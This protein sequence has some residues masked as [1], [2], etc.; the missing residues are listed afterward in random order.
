MKTHNFDVTQGDWDIRDARGKSARVYAPGAGKRDRREKTWYEKASFLKKAAIAGALGTAGLG[1][2]AISR[3]KIRQ[4]VISDAKDL[5][6]GVSKGPA[7]WFVKRQVLAEAVIARAE[8]FAQNEEE[9]KTR[10]TLRKVGI[11]AA[12]LG[13]AALPAALPMLSIS[14]R[15]TFPKL[16]NPKT[17]G[18]AFVSDYIK[19][20]NRALGQGPQGVIAGKYIARQRSKT[21]PGT[22]GRFMA[23]HYARFRAGPREA[24]KHWDYE[25]GESIHQGLKKKASTESHIAA[26]MGAFNKGREAV[27]SAIDQ[28]LWNH[29]KS[30]I[31][32]ISEVAKNPDPLIQG[33][34][35]RLAAHKANAVKDNYAP[36]AAISPTLIAGGAGLA[37]ASRRKTDEERRQS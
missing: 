3:P 12:V 11:G 27:H 26:R 15:K 18:G 7:E 30:E 23:D 24:L 5:A 8:R 13:A 20:A 29:G 6:D 37:V 9:S 35:R 1:I 36:L 25:V 10:S 16:G 17:D 33:H 31:D 28:Q 2:Y 14:A 22:L 34:F 21:Q 19:G 32:A 4:Q